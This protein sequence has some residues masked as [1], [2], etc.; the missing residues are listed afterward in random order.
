MSLFANHVCYKPFTYENLYNRWKLHEQS[1]WQTAEVPMHEDIGDWND[2][3]SYPQKEFLTNIFRFFT[4]GDIDVATAYSDI[5]LPLL[6]KLSEAKM[7][8]MSFSSRE[9]TH[10]DAYSHIIETLGMPSQTYVEFLKYK[11]MK[12]KQDY[13]MAFIYECKKLIIKDPLDFTIEDKELI[14]SSLAVFSAFTEGMQ[15]FSTFAMLLVFPLNSLMKGMGQIVSWSIADESQHVDGMMEIFHIFLSTNPDIDKK[16][17][18][19]KIQSVAVEM[20]NLEREFI[21]YVFGKYD[22]ND[23]FGLT[24]TRL[25]KYIEFVADYRLTQMGFSRLYTKSD[26]ENPLPDLAV[27]INAPIHTNFFENTSTDYGNA[28]ATGTWSE[29]WG[30]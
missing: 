23:F 9:A 8:M 3:L 25:E 13:I 18:E 27:M 28:S 12:A 21:K 14:A 24:P 22:V 6:G 26:A 11:E 29:I 7:M 4:Q 5:F 15:L 20:V 10:I 19:H 30:K 17:L 2:K 16:R 1:H